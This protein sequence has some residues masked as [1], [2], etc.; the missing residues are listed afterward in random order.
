MAMLRNLR[1]LL[2][3]GCDMAP[4][5]ARLRDPE[6]I[7]NSRQFPFRF[8]SAYKAL[9]GLAVRN[10]R[11][12]LGEGTAPESLRDALSDALTLSIANMPELP[13][14]TLV[15]CDSSGSMEASVSGQS[16]LSRAEAAFVLG[17]L[18]KRLAPDSTVGVLGETWAVLPLSVRDNI[19]TNVS[20]LAAARVGHATWAFLALQWATIKRE[21]YDRIILLS[22][23]QCYGDDRYG[24]NVAPA[25]AAYRRAVNPQARLISIDLAG[26]GTAQEPEDD[27]L[28]LLL[29][30]WSERVLELINIWEAGEGDMLRRIDNYAV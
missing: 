10:Y 18:V 4:Y 17:A 23:M 5:V 12:L 11:L 19:L 30:G 22:D 2:D 25:L 15:A 3:A 8:W 29:A 16:K 27:P 6:T 9:T 24:A 14:R 7:R 1:N 28:T 21:R 20:L 26:Y 13:G